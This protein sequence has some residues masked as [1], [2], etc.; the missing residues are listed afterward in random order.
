MIRSII[1]DNNKNDINNIT[2][3]INS[4]NNIEITEV[5]ANP[6]HAL[7]SIINNNIELI[8]LEIDLPNFNGIEFIKDL[9]TNVQIIIASKRTEYAIDAFE[10]NVLDY[11][12]KPISIERFIKTATRIYKHFD[13]QT[14]TN[15]IE[16]SSVYIKVNKKQVKIY[17]DQILYVESVG[18]YVK[19]FC[20]ENKSFL[21]YTTLKKL[22]TFL[23]SED[24]IRVHRSYAISTARVTAMEGNKIEIGKYNI[25]VGR[26]YIND[27]KNVIINRKNS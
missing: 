8:F 19:I 26:L 9:P 15:L 12:V 21:S 4:F 3:L 22:I 25:P 14:S 13:K 27:V 10:L 23:P 5:Y 2:N 18:D 1:I 17:H 11:L 24:F 7:N 6:F 16:R 20:K